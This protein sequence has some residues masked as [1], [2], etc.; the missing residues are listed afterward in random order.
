MSVWAPVC[1]LCKILVLG[2]HEGVLH[3]LGSNRWHSC[4][5]P[6]RG[7]SEHFWR[8]GPAGV[9]CDDEQPDGGRLWVVLMWCGDRQQVDR[10]CCHLH[11]HQGDS[12][13]VTEWFWID[14]PLA[15]LEGKTFSCIKNAN[16]EHELLPFLQVCLCWTI[17]WVGTRGAVSQLNATTVR[18]TGIV[19][20]SALQTC[21]L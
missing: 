5:R 21:Q 10:W 7:Q 9:H 8:P 6:R 3:Q 1:Q 14:Y 17:K 20:S 12:R 18:N 2:E 4:G 15:M 19:S 11:L 16:S 13:W